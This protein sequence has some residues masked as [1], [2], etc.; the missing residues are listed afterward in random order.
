MSLKSV[1][2]SL[3]HIIEMLIEPSFLTLHLFSYN[4]FKIL[5]EIRK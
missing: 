1:K 4:L 5:K 3:I 2:K